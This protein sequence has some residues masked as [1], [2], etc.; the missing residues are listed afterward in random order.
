[1]GNVP[2]ENNT[3]QRIVGGRVQHA[4]G[5]EVDMDDQI[6]MSDNITIGPQPSEKDLND[7]K[8]SGFKS[9]VNFRT[10]G[11]EEQPI[12]PAQEGEKVSDLG[13][14][15]LNVPV[16][17]QE[18]R[19]ELV[20]EFREQLKGLP[21][22]LFAHCKTGKRAGAMVMMD[23]A[24]EQGLSGQQTIQKALAMGFECDQPELKQFVE[25]YVDSHQK[26]A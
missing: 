8:Q 17:M 11:E 9:I 3:K 19:P 16:S 20:D 4:I 2:V 18:M 14:R 22:P 13:L 24:V 7:L 21:K 1:M 15:Y 25:N 6:R 10:A 23:L 26:S 5:A 12:S